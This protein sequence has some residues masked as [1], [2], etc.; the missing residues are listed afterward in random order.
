M[1]IDQDDDRFEFMNQTDCRFDYFNCLAAAYSENDGNDLTDC[2]DVDLEGFFRRL[3]RDSREELEE[4]ERQK[5]GVMEY[6]EALEKEKKGVEVALID[7]PE[8]DLVLE[9]GF[10]KRMMNQN[11]TTNS[12]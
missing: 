8:L 2:T 3:E 1:R 9:L 11:T 7:L 6:Q 5:K 10:P 4:M 12:D